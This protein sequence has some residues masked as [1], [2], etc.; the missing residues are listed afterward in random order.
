MT[1]CRLFESDLGA[2]ASGELEAAAT[3]RIRAHLEC[4]APCRDELARENNLRQTLMGLSPVTAPKILESRVQ[5]AIHAQRETRAQAWKPGR[6]T[7][8][9]IL[10]A[11]TLTVALLVPGLRTTP[12]Q[13]WTE[14]EIASGRQDVMYTLALTAKIIDR[15]Q[16]DAV[17]DVFVDKLPRAINDSFKM[18]K[19]NNSGGNG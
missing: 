12:S 7:A 8:A 11:A 9:I 2:Y 15:T 3:D 10:A 5:A 14:Q 6:L 18:A 19:P 4:C 13:Q 16:K 1:D 17:I